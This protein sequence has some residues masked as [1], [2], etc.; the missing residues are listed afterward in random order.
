MQ[1]RPKIKIL[2]IED[3]LIDRQMV[4]R[5][6]MKPSQTAAE[7]D[8]ECAGSLAESFEQLSKNN[9]DVILLDLGLPDS[10]GLE[11]VDRV[12]KE[13]PRIP[14]IVL[15]GLDDNETGFTAIKKGAAD[16]LVKGITVE[17]QLMKSILYAIERKRV[18]AALQESQMQLAAAQRLAK[19]G[20]WQ[21]DAATQ[22]T[23]WSEEMFH[24]HGLDPRAGIPSLKKLSDMVHPED[25]E[26]WG[27]TIEKALNSASAEEIEFRIIRQDGQC[28]WL[29]ARQATS[30]PLGSNCYYGT[31]TDITERKKT[32]EDLRKSEKV[33]KMAYEQLEIANRE[34]KEMQSQIVQNEKLASIGQL[35]AGVAHEMNTPVGFVASNFQTLESYVKK[36]RT[37]M[38]MYEDIVKQ[39]E[40]SDKLQ[41]L[42]KAE[43]IAQAYQT[44]KMDFIL[45]DIQGLFSESREGL[46]RV[47]DIIQNLRD[48]SRIDQAENIGEYN[49]ND[50]INATL[51]VA[52]NE[53]K[54]DAEV[55]TEFSE[56]PTI[57][58]NSGQIN[59]VLLNIIL[60][61]VQAIKSEGDEK[62]GIITIK[63]Y[64]VDNN[65]FC[66]ISDNGP[67]IA[68]ETI[69]KIFD[70]FFTTKPVGKGT[71]LGLSI[72]YDI[73]VN[74][75]NGKILVDSTAGKGATFTIILPIKTKQ[76]NSSRNV[77][78]YEM[79]ENTIR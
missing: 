23:T 54:Y 38:E 57:F 22:K 15:T 6:L 5:T 60:N 45:K 50:G 39:I 13:K 21:Y 20:S 10:N 34:L 17:Y 47:T 30:G 18:E 44:M 75:H 67:G 29:I 24:I 26:L 40:I 72:S 42:K 25:R 12:A 51:S 2:L 16:Y 46:E 77:E 79:Q 14:I 35:A 8:I 58:C 71:G 52:R 19:L 3:D 53:I 28:R 32:E 66:Q 43:A 73:I 64:A 9:F 48:F 1:S 31:L 78:I 49:I 55:K 33:A 27:K 7:F 62:K 11:T 76:E 56:V 69:K 68:P 74:K 41:L 61:A 36:F 65:V 37:L 70:P 4:K 59:Q 63:T